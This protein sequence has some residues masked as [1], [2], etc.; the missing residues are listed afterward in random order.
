[1]RIGFCAILLRP[2]VARPEPSAARVSRCG[3]GR[4]PSSREASSPIKAAPKIGNDPHAMPS[5]RCRL[6]ALTATM[7]PPQDALLRRRLPEKH[8]ERGHDKLCR[9]IRKGGGAEQYN[10]NKKYTEA[11]LSRRR[12]APR[13]RR[14]RRATSA[15]RLCIGRRRR[16]SCECVVPRTAGCAR[17]V[18]GGAG[19][20][21]AEAEENNLSSKVLNERFNR[22]LVQSANKNTT[23]SCAVRSAGRAGRRTWAGRRRTSFGV[24]Q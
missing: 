2:P 9:N 22:W 21:F 3:V 7:Q 4:S 13:T 11:V 24:V 14:A 10:A 5:L 20:A 1:M 6:P 23:A 8:W 17:V 19:E 16:A 12:R 18:P 15:R